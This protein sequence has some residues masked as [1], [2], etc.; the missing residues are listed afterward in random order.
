MRIAFFGGS[1]DPPH[2]GHL[3]IAV[4]AADRLRLDRVLFAPAGLQPLK[5]EQSAAASYSDRL[6]M[7]RLLLDEARDERL[8]VSELDAPRPD[9]RPNYTYETL[10]A[11][12]RA[13]APEDE[14]FLLTGADALL[15][16]ANWHRALD[17]IHSIDLIVAARPGFELDLLHASFAKLLAD[18]TR[19]NVLEP[20][21]P[22]VE[23]VVLDFED[24]RRRGNPQRSTNFYLLTD[25]A[26]DIAATEVRAALARDPH[27]PLPAL[28]PAVTDYIR[29][30]GLYRSP[31]C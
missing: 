22:G 29:S 19:R 6:V 9:G 31:E 1:F 8:E 4:A 26:Q 15:T 12:R 14:V 16:L 18:G 10:I 27:G 28:V 20:S 21:E 11:L 17:L 3:R 5:R 24:E 25:L 2:L 7:L 23:H 30:H 13:L